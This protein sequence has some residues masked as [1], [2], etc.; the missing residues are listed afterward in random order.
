MIKKHADHCF[1][2]TIGFAY[3]SSCAH[4]QNL[5]YFQTTTDSAYPCVTDVGL[6]QP[7]IGTVIQTITTTIVSSYFQT[8]KLCDGIPRAVGDPTSVFSVAATITRA[9]WTIRPDKLPDMSSYFAAN[10]SLISLL[11]PCSIQPQDCASLWRDWELQYISVFSKGAD[12]GNIPDFPYCDYASTDCNKCTIFGGDVQLLYFPTETSQGICATA[13]ANAKARRQAP[14]MNTTTTALSNV[15]YAV[16]DGHTFYSGHVYISFD[17]VFAS[18]PCA[19]TT[20]G[21]A[22]TGGILTLNSADLSSLRYPFYVEDKYSFNYADLNSPVPWSAYGA[23]S[24]CFLGFCQTISTPY[25][26]Q[27]M[28]P[29]AITAMDPAWANCELYWGGLHDPPHALQTAGELSNPTTTAAPAGGPKQSQVPQTQATEAG[30]KQTSG[31]GTGN[32]N[33][34]GSLDD[35]SQNP[36][37]GNSGNNPGAVLDPQS[38]ASML[39]STLQVTPGQFAAQ[40]PDPV[41]VATPVTVVNGQTIQAVDPSGAVVGGTTLRPGLPAVTIYNTP[42]SVGSAGLVV[43]VGSDA[44]TIPIPIAPAAPL[45]TPGP[46]VAVFTI[47][48]QTYTAD[49]SNG[50]VIGGITLTPGSSPV[51]ISGNIVSVGPTGVVVTPLNGQQAGQAVTYTFSAG[52]PETHITIGGQ[53]FDILSSGGVIHIGTAVL[54]PGGT[55]VAVNGHTFSFGPSGVV[56]DGTST[57]PFAAIATGHVTFKDG[58]GFDIS[59]YGGLIHIGTGVLTPGGSPITINGHVYSA[60][61]SGHV[62]IDGTSTIALSP[63]KATASVSKANFEAVATYI[64]SGVGGGSKATTVAT[65]TSSTEAVKAVSTS[66]STSKKGDGWRIGPGTF[67]IVSAVMSLLWFLL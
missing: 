1:G 13:P 28:I 24:E 32:N 66:Q 54:T 63:A 5:L 20:I 47:G 22:M 42:I 6:F 21:T 53:S 18:N 3:A 60:D 8:T 11:N 56:V 7:Y 62:I 64:V 9:H 57:V 44:K 65:T 52:L 43:G 46:S 61:G 48:G 23:Q 37:S 34:G 30:P 41:N 26:P 40:S 39:M 38:V 58:G 19:G 59:S 31:S 15:S 10:P 27:L 51:T 12:S 50:V 36:G 33:P 45:I 67:K 14:T 35:P 17:T 29:S 16:L 55:P 25:N 49:G 4:I 2:I